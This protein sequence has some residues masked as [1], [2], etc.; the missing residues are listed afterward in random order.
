M[1]EGN[2]R[3]LMTLEKGVKFECEWCDYLEC[4]G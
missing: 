4:D 1:G 2:M 3:R